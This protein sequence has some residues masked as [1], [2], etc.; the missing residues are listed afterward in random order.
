MTAEEVLK[1]SERSALRNNQVISKVSGKNIKVKSKSHWKSFSA[2]CFITIMIAVFA[3]V[4]SSGN[5]IP[6]AISERLIEETD[7]QY[8]DAVGSKEIV[9]QQAMYKGEIPENTAS[10]LKQKNVLTGY[11]DSN[12]D[13]VE[14]NQHDGGVSLLVL[15]N[16]PSVSNVTRTYGAITSGTY[17]DKTGRLVT[18]DDF[19]TAVKSDTELYSAFTD[20]TYGR[21][22]YYFDDAAKQVFKEIGTSRHNYKSESD[23]NQ[24]V[25]KLMGSGS[26]VD[27]NS[28]SVVEK[29]TTN[30]GKSETYYDYEENGTN[31]SSRDGAEAFISAVGSKNTANSSM[32][33]TLNSADA[34]KVADATS[35]EQRSS[36]YYALFMENISQMMAGEGNDSKINDAMNYLY[37]SHETEVVDVNT[38]E[39][40][41]MKG[42]ALDSPSL[43]AILADTKVNK[44]TAKNYSNDRILKTVENKLGTNNGSS[45]IVNTVASVGDKIKGAIGRLLNTGGETAS[46][47]TLN[48]VNK[49]VDKSLVNNSFETIKGIDAGEFLV[50][51]AV[52]VGRKL[53]E[54]SGA[55]AGDAEAAAK[56]ARLN[57]T[58]LAMDAEVDRMNRSPF[59]VTSKN[60][61]LGSIM[62]KLAITSSRNSGIIISGMKSFANVVGDA[63]LSLVPASYAAAEESYMTSFGDYCETLGS[64]NA[65]G[66]AQCAE[67]AT[68]DTSTLD[69]IYK[70][71]GFIEFVNQNT[72]LSSSGVR[73]IN[74]NSVLGDFALYNQGRK[75][76]SGVVDGGI[77]NSIN[78][79][80]SSVSFVSSIANIV[81]N[82]VGASDKD[83]RIASGAEYVNSAS[84]PSWNTTY[85]YA[86][87]YMSLARAIESLKQYSGGSSAYNNIKYFEGDQNPV[88]AY[89]EKYISKK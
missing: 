84:N 45:A 53:A 24:V 12:G 76:P 82:F 43:Y 32:E 85:K 2:L 21:A 25:D 65:V 6:A 3:V 41:K 81:K 33:A 86:Q 39:I 89:L 54:A 31:A 38:G 14:T 44:E 36:L 10:V 49:T 19:I 29:T 71:P 18:A 17:G 59:D 72:T 8:A 88:T 56:Y 61:F 50:K 58:I 16:G 9:F 66:T 62:Y 23:F 73:T 1:Q 27:V 34:L 83:K 37:E 80:S 64:I 67:V 51:G 46:V 11:V 47:E 4:F 79:N 75:A 69:G 5:L 77:L 15:G 13:F 78:N 48:S 35:E 60:T 55:T 28:V 30:N 7:V 63:T 57:R 70:D 20:A 40:I 42:T 68:F 74:N 52:N 87:R 22:A 26:N